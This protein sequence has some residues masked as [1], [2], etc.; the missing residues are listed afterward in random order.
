MADTEISFVGQ[1]K[2]EQFFKQ[3]SDNTKSAKNADK[4]FVGVIASIV[5]RDITDHF[6]K[7]SG[8][9]GPWQKWSEL[10]ADHMQK[11]GKGGNKILQDTGTLRKNLQPQNWRKDPQGI[12][13]FNPVQY[14]ARHD[15]G[16]SGMP[17]RKFMWLSSSATENLAKTTLGFILGRDG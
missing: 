16:L 9:S 3:M 17:E 14:A 7:Q 12:V 5:F 1:K 6:S 13:F 2:V 15:E 4:A 8:P 11:I 10:Y